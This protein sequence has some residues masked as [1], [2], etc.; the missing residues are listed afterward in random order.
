MA[1]LCRPW[2]WVQGVGVSGRVPTGPPA[3]LGRCNRNGESCKVALV[4]S[5][6]L[7]QPSGLGL[8]AVCRRAARIP[9]LGR[10][11]FVSWYKL[12]METVLQIRPK[13]PRASRPLLPSHCLLLWDSGRPGPILVWG[14]RVYHWLI[15]LIDAG[16]WCINDVLQYLVPCSLGSQLTVPGQKH[17]PH[18]DVITSNCVVRCWTIAC[19]RINPSSASRSKNS[20]LYSVLIAIPMY[21]A[22]VYRPT[23]CH[24]HRRP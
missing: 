22:Q 17:H 11:G 8:E 1:G 3:G 18:I 24:A 7:W 15:P 10:L 9:G 12:P 16:T 13:G 20:S 14:Q 2:A 6:R 23:S 19:H 21:Q 5:P 4:W